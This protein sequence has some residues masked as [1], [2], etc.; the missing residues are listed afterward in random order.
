MLISGPLLNTALECIQHIV[1]Y[2]RTYKC[3]VIASYDLHAMLH[4]CM[5]DIASD[6]QLTYLC[7]D[8]W[9]LEVVMPEPSVQYLSVSDVIL[10]VAFSFDRALRRMCRQS[11]IRW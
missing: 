11:P 9:G 5:R 1:P 4:V 7:T 8:W 10:V 2:I 3:V 6:Q